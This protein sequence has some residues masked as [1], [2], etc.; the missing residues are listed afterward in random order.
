MNAR[1]V[2]AALS[3]GML[4]V[5]PAAAEPPAVF[6]AALYAPYR[7]SKTYDPC[8]Q[9]C[10]TELAKLLKTAHAKKLIDYDPVCQ[11]QQVGADHFMMFLG[12]TGATSDD[13]SATMKKVGKPGTWVLTLKWVDGDWKV[14]DIVETRAGKPVSLRQRLT[15]AG[16]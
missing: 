14:A 15:A 9:H 4:L 5:P 16:A 12:S 2:I 6:I 10:T 1:F 13:Y 3:A 8:V 7:D 11:C